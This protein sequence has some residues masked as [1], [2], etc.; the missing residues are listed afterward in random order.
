MPT[1]RAAIARGDVVSVTRPGSAEFRSGSQRSRRVTGS[2]IERLKRVIAFLQFLCLPENC[3]AVVNITTG[4]SLGMSIEDR[5]AAPLR[6]K[7]EL[8]SLNMGS[9]NF[10]LFHLLDRYKPGI[11]GVLLTIGTGLGNARFTNR[12][13]PAKD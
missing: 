2:P 9:I 12:S 10:G 11:I 4:G 7:P 3:D 1:L 5:L 8:C 13:A 6:A